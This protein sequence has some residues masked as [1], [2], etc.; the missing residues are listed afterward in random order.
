MEGEPRLG[1]EKL[2]QRGEAQTARAALVHQQQEFIGRERPSFDQLFLESSR[3][4][5]FL[6][7]G[8]SQNS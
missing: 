2:E 3:F 4:M 6:C 7:P 8:P 1:L 5:E